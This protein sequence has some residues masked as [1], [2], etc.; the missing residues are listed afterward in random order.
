MKAKDQ[1]SAQSWWRWRWYGLPEEG[2]EIVLMLNGDQAVTV[3]IVEVD[4][5]MPE[6]AA[7]RP[8]NSMLKPYTWSDS[9]VI[10]QTLELD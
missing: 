6:G 5:G 1:S 3:K 8:D 10:F 2:A 9:M 4:Y 7:L